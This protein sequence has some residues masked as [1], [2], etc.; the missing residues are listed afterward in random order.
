MSDEQNKSHMLSRRS[1]LQTMALGAGSA[2][3]AACAIPAMPA[4]APVGGE[5][6][7]DAENPY[8]IYWSMFG[9]QEAELASAQVD[10]FNEETGL[11][12]VFVSMGWT[13]IAQKVQVAIE[14]GNPPD[15]VS[16]W[17]QAYTWGPRGLLLPLE[18]YAD[19]DGFDGTGWSPAAWEALWSNGHMWG[20]GHTLNVWALHI[21]QKLY[22]EAGFSV[23]SPPKS[24]D[25]LDVMAENLTEYDDDGN[26]TRLGFVPWRNAPVMHWGWANGAKYYDEE[27][28]TI[29]ANEDK[30][31]LEVLEWYA[32][33]AEKYDIEKVDRFVSGFD[34]RSSLTEDPWYTD[35]IGMQID[36]AWKRSWI[37]RYAPELEYTVVKSPYGPGGTEPISMVQIGAMFNVPT[38]AKNPEGGWQLAKFMAG[39]QQ[40]IE[41]GQLVGDVPPL[42]D[43][44]RSPDFLDSLPFNELFVE[45]TEGTAGRAQPRLPVL[46]LYESELSRVVDEVTHGKTTPQE[47]LDELTAK[48][49][50]ELD[51]FREQTA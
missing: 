27:T 32:S 23:D 48:I 1:F 17:S 6:A 46:A 47:G 35:K 13:N 42:N 41:F 12:A 37:P 24:F 3:L 10:R 20:T 21:N 18:D 50:K 36:G 22:E 25:E 28:D 4:A 43:A 15:M 11:N 30:G 45:L 19:R 16:L 34:G 39:K 40:Q 8:I 5:T 29:T 2:M 38:G 51:D 49:Q 9:L 44:A 31:L 26:I 33:Y 7:P 14:G